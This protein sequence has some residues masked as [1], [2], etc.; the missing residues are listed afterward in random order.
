MNF[1]RFLLLALTAASLLNAGCALFEIDDDY[2]DDKPQ[3]RPQD[4]EYST[5]GMRH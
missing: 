4:W 3:N 1:R 5:P 2:V